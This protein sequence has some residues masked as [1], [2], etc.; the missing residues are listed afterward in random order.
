MATKNISLTE[1]AYERLKECKREGESFSDVVERLTRASTSLRD[2][3]GALPGLGA[4]VEDVR[5][6]FEAEMEQRD[7]L[8]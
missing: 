4:A 6:D 2:G 3:V 7:V 8:R 1:E 5:E